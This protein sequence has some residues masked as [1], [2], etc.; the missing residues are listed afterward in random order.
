MS[1]LTT[2]EDIAQH[3]THIKKENLTV[4]FVPTM[5]ALHDGHL[6]L[7]RYAQQFHQHIIVSIFVNPTQFNNASDLKAYPRTLDED[8]TLLNTLEGAITIYAPSPIEVYSGEITSNT[9]AFGKL[10]TV[11]EGE[12]RPG[13]FDG[14]GTVLQLLFEQ[15]RP[16]EAFFGEKDFQQLQ[17]VRKLVDVKNFDIKITG[18]PIHRETNGLAMSSR[19]VR[20]TK[21]HKEAAPF[22]YETL[23]QVKNDFGTK[24]A[25]RLKDFVT[26]QF[27]TQELLEL[28]YFEIANVKNLHTL[29]RKRTNEK[30]RAFIAVWAGDVR[31][32]DNIALN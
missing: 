19:N 3:I 29:S 6:S 7:I 8:V 4:G 5:G 23:S 31:L 25:N 26:Q 12:H 14:V 16:D 24:S 1:V 10:E 28:E 2:R 22:I 11:M 15:V 20:L 32:I 27:D 9:Y 21:V 13:H 30:Y 18:C 17:V